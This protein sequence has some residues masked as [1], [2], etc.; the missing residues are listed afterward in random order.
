VTDHLKDVLDSV[1]PL[2]RALDFVRVCERLGEESLVAVS[3]GRLSDAASLNA[4]L[5]SFRSMMGDEEGALRALRATEELDSSNTHRSIDTAR[6]LLSRMGRVEEANTIAS[7]LLNH[8]SLDPLTK[9]EAL[10]L[11]GRI[12]A[13]ENRVDD[14][15]ELLGNAERVA[16]EGDLDAMFWDRSLVNVLADRHVVTDATLIYLRTLAQRANAESDEDTAREVGKVLAKL[17]SA[18]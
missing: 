15:A 7:R 6:H 11:L 13:S 9:H 10:A 14:A 4:M 3:D 17:A 8:S 18:E 5:G 1:K 12:A 16:T 2:I